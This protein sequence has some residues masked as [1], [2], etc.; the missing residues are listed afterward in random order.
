MGKLSTEIGLAFGSIGLLSFGGAAI[1]TG[2]GAPLGL[3]LVGLG[4]AGVKAMEV[5]EH[6][7]DDEEESEDAHMNSLVPYR[8]L[9]DPPYLPSTNIFPSSDL[10]D[11]LLP[12]AK[13]RPSS[14]L[15]FLER[16]ED[17]GFLSDIARS[18]AQSVLAMVERHPNPRHLRVTGSVR[19]TFFGGTKFKF[20][21]VVS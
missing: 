4:L 11:P 18:N 2:V 13:E 1:S 16:K 17:E 20:D 9:Y 19:R 8:Q 3:I 14:T 15:R 21:A 12:L 7:P 6:I 5:V 10:G